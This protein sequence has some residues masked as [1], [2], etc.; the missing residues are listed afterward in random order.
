[1]LGHSHQTCVNGKEVLMESQNSVPIDTHPSADAALEHW[2]VVYR[3][4]MS[5]LDGSKLQRGHTVEFHVLDHLAAF[6][7]DG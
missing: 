2:N 4:T 5:S 1:M 6:R 7:V 3:F